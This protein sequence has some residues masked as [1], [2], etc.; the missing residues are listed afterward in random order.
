VKSKLLETPPSLPQ[1][2]QELP[3]QSEKTDVK[4]YIVSN[5]TEELYEEI[6][7]KDQVGEAI[8][9]QQNAEYTLTATTCVHVLKQFVGNTAPAAHENNHAKFEKIAV[10]VY[11]ERAETEEIAVEQQKAGHATLTVPQD[12]KQK[13]DEVVARDKFEEIDVLKQNADDNNTQRQ[14]HHHH[15]HEQ[16]RRV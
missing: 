7:E 11:M 16:A 4:V 15:Q 14:H 2:H 3:R 12:I 8:K 5:R 1:E 13:T 9:T 6:D 10:K